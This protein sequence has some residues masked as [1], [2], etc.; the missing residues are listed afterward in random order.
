MNIF[1]ARPSLDPLELWLCF[2]GGNGELEETGVPLCCRLARNAGRLTQA[3]VG[4][5]QY[6]RVRACASLQAHI[7][8][9]FALKYACMK[10]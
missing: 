7:P 10:T 4:N 1:S 8:P 2:C 3:G 5:I 6:V 9:E